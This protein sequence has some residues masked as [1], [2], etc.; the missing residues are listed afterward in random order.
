MGWASGWAGACGGMSDA[1]V[2][3]VGT[4]AL[5]PVWVLARDEAGAWGETGS[6]TMACC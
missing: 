6:L 5:E 3:V 1:V 4:A 2:A